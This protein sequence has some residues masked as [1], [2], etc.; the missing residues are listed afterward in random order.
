MKFCSQCGSPTEILIPEGD[1]RPRHVCTNKRCGAI[2]YQ[3]PRII[4]GCL[5]TFEDKVLLCKRAIEPR[6]GYWTLPAGFMENGESTAEGALRESAEE[7]NANCQ[8]EELYT[9][10]SLPHINQVYFFYRASLS[11]L[12][13]GAGEESLEVRLFSENEIPW[14]DLA[15]TVVEKSLKYYFEDL[16]NKTF[17]LREEVVQPQKTLQN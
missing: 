7:A 13:F 10:F 3:N 5:P 8:I 1:N 4:T 12:N 11:D 6:Y 17:V 2:H 16:K 9:L 15:F 14:N